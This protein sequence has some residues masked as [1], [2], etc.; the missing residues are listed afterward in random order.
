M[1]YRI[2]KR[3]KTKPYKIIRKEDGVVVGSSSSL[4][5]AK[6]SIGYRMGA[7]HKA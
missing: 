4:A 2:V 6:R 7:E 5:K 3:G 1:P